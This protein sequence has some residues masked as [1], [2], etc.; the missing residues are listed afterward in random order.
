MTTPIDQQFRT[1]ADPFIALARTLTPE[2]WQQDSPCDGWTAAD[3]VDHVITTQQAFFDG[4]EIDLPAA[5]GNRDPAATLEVHVE[6]VV[7][8]LSDP[9]VP[10]TTFDGFF[11]PTTV[12]DTLL[13]FYGFDMV[14]HRW[15]VGRATGREVT[16]DDAELDLLET[17]IEGFGENL[18]LE[19]ICKP[20][21]EVAPG[22][23]RQER[24]LGRL[25]RA[26]V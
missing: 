7:N 15:D 26:M 11:G 12:G 20:A 18:Y 25:G 24:L 21:M 4:H 9:A 23:G 13:R 5:S 17:A 16:F 2:E 8:S 1:L 19:G 3:V 10:A 6:R 22:A 14:V